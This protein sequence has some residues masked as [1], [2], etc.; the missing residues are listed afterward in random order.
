MFRD[1]QI[2]IVT[3]FVVVSSVDVKRVD[4]IIIIIII[5]NYNK[6]TSSTTP[7]GIHS[8]VGRTSDCT[9]RGH[10]SQL[11]HITSAEIDD[12]IIST[13]IFPL[14]LIQEGR[15]SNTGENMCTKYWL[16]A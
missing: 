12:E 16:N 13:V 10:K 8:T 2:V 6:T 5:I 15:L 4:C 11:V 3:N 7:A 9:P 14:P 1:I